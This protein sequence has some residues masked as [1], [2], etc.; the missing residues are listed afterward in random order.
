M[1]MT[2]MT[3]MKK[4][5]HTRT[6]TALLAL[7]LAGC[8]GGGGGGGG[9]V[10][11]SAPGTG[12][13]DVSLTDAAVDSAEQ[14]LVQFTGIAVKPA[15][16]QARD[17]DLDGD[18]QTCQDRL[19][20][21]PPSTT[22]PGE[23]TIRCIDLMELDGNRSTVILRDEDLDAGDYEWIRLDVDA[24]RGIMDS[25][26][27]LDDGSQESLW[28]PS[29]SQSGLKLNTPFTIEDGGEHSLVIDFDLRKS[30]NNPQGFPDYRLKPS[31]RLIDIGATG[32]GSIEGMVEASLL[33]TEGCTEDAYAVYVYTGADAVTGDEGSE[34]APLTSAAVALDDDSGLW[35]Y[36]VGFLP[37]ETYTV[38]FTCEAGNDSPDTGGD[39]IE[40]ITSPDSPATVTAGESTTVDFAPAG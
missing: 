2:E 22:P 29:G 33:T 13:L 15:E 27:V 20:E 37:P 30:V 39:D 31:L 24:E 25:I 9:G 36:E 14:V 10:G 23:S 26:I 35:R 38:V 18:S 6:L 8:G 40:F 16:G 19:D 21:I 28:V 5:M 1:G 17:L 32:S 34:N 12:S 4:C 11:G 3:E 7:G